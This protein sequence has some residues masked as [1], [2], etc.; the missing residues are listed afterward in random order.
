MDKDLERALALSLQES[1]STRHL[2]RRFQSVIPRTMVMIMIVFSLRGYRKIERPRPNIRGPQR[3]PSMMHDP[4]PPSQSARNTP[5][6]SFLSE[7]AQMERERLERLKRLCEQNADDAGGISSHAKRQHILSSEIHANGRANVA[8]TSSS[9]V[10][11]GLSATHFPPQIGTGLVLQKSDISFAITA[12]YAISVSWI[13]ELFAPSTPVI[14]V[15]QPDQSGQPIIK[16]VLPNWVMT[17]PFLPNGR[18]C[19]HMKFMLTGRLRIVISTANLIDRDWRNI[20]NA[21]WLQDLPPRSAPITHDPKAIDDFPSIMQNV[22]RAVNVRRRLPTCQQTTLM[23]AVRDMG[24]RTGKG[25]A[26]KDLLIESQGNKVKN[27]ITGEYGPVP[28]TDAYYRDKGIKWVVID[29][30]NY[31]EG[32]SREHAALEP[33]YLGGLAIITRSFARIHETNLQKQGNCSHLRQ[34]QRRS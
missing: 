25:K 9:S 34:P 33:R 14:I 18:G 12:S 13:Y 10:P 19:Q 32:S 23:K 22:L 5:A 2:R 29:D 8:S 28:Q 1:Q 16:N 31:G 20:E 3:N 21:I 30:S 6:A 27:Q 17:V 11:S 24:L 15:A 7:R 26:A 4:E